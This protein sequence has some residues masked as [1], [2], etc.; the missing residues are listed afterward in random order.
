[1]SAAKSRIQPKR[2]TNKQKTQTDSNFFP[3]R[4]LRL[5]GPRGDALVQQV[6]MD[7]MRWFRSSTTAS[8]EGG[9]SS[10][11]SRDSEVYAWV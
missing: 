11:P 8:K 9:R 7:L 3:E 4:G 5:N 10:A 6:R 2:K 1:M